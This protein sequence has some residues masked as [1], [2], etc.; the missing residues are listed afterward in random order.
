MKLRIAFVAD[1]TIHGGKIT[2]PELVQACVE[3]LY[4]QDGPF[5]DSFVDYIPEEID[6]DNFEMCIDEVSVK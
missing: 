1:C 2:K 6:I 3:W 4:D 5:S